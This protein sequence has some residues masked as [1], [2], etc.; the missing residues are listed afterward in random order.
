MKQ[1]NFQTIIKKL[2]K[3]GMSQTEIMDKTGVPQ[4]TVSNL[5]SGRQKTVTYDHGKALVG[6]IE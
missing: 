3:Q 6:L 2:V 4:C 1:T 5:L